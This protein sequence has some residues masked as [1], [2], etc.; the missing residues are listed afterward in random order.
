MN[1]IFIATNLKHSTSKEV[2]NL[3]EIRKIM[4]DFKKQILGLLSGNADNSLI[5]AESTVNERVIP[6]DNGASIVIQQRKEVERE[7]KKV[8]PQLDFRSVDLCSGET[9]KV[10]T[11]EEIISATKVIISLMFTR[12]TCYISVLQIQ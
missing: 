10:D 11:I 1:L 9:I 8:Q 6:T 5:Q 2:N 12:N 3:N 4:P 7:V